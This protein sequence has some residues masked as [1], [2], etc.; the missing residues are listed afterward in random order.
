M[1]CYNLASEIDPK[2]VD[3]LLK[4]SSLWFEKEELGK[5]RARRA[6]RGH[7][8]HP[9]RALYFLLAALYFLLAGPPAQSVGAA[10]AASASRAGPAASA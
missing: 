8:H 7:W 5:V 1:A 4:R 2:A 9:R 6:A 3:V 10:H